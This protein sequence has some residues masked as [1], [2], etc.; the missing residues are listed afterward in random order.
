MNL[1]INP[2]SMVQGNYTPPP[3]GLLY[4]AAM[5]KDT[6][7]YDAALH[8]SWPCDISKPRVVGVPIYTMGRHNSLAYLREAKKQGAVTVAGGPHIAVMLDQMIEQYGHFV[9]HFVVGDGELAWKAI[10]NGE[11]M[12]QVIR[13]RVE[14]LDSLPQPA[15]EK[16]DFHQYPA[17]GKGIYRGHNLA[18][19]PRISIILGR[20]C[21]GHCTFC[22]AWWVNG[23]LRMHG[24]KWMA[25]HLAYLW[26]MGV[27]HLV[28]QDDNLADDYQATMNL[29]DA[30]E[31]FTFSWCGT[32]RVDK[33]DEKLALRMAKTGCYLLAFGI[34]SG[35]QII[36]NKMRKQLNLSQ[37]FEARDACRK[38]KIRF[39]A[40]IIRGFPH[41]TSKTERE[42]AE[43]LR[44]LQP[45]AQGS[46]GATWV[47][48][49]T[50]LYQ[51]CKR[52]GL[53]DDDFWLG[54]EPYYIYRGG[55]E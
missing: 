12:P 52:A 46:V 28:F 42:T 39:T 40:L 47:F 22:S 53:I 18:T 9:D 32:A 2:S 48:P 43:F 23:K 1:L 8:K 19:I 25:T 13:L 29:C 3:L 27:R 51:S 36:L 10:C 35:S 50:A 54:K 6:E 21:T 24:K 37:S 11:K 5:D 44:Q 55:L 15:W 41:S 7:I 17:R 45:D 34:E 26:D 49:G 16:I 30:L 14:S 33:V 4:L 20:G 38:A 31:K